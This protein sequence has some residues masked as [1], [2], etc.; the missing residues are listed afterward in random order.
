MRR[1]SLCPDQY[2]VY[3]VDTPFQ[4]GR[5]YLI[6]IHQYQTPSKAN[7]PTYQ[8]NVNLLYLCLVPGILGT[9][10]SMWHCTAR[11]SKRNGEPYVNNL[12]I[13]E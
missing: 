2:A 3:C 9:C 12:N 10:A 4:T 5:M 6:Y 13:Q 11:N 1:K 7:I 8:R